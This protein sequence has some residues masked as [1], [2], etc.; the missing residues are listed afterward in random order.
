MRAACRIDA[1]AS[2]AAVP[3][4]L[5]LISALLLVGAGFLAGCSTDSY[6]WKMGVQWVQEAEAEKRA[7]NAAGFPQYNAGW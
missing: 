4:G 1:A 2:P 3:F 6:R 5:R 7:L